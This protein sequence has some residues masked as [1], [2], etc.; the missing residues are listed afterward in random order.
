M[1][2]QKLA[3][4]RNLLLEQRRQANEDLEAERAA[5]AQNEEDGVEDATDES[6]SDLDESTAFDL[7]DRN[8]HLIEEIDAAL[9]R[10]DDG[11]Y[12]QCVRCGKPIDEER[13][14]AMP[15]A[16]YDAACQAAIEAAEGTETPSL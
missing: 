11:T 4:F 5:A 9:Q 14:K 16:R 2:Q 15:T 3:Y 6:K 8:T 7:A 12:G 13:L 10:I 1:D